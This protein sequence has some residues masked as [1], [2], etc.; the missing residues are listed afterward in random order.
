LL[1]TG[2]EVWQQTGLPRWLVDVVAYGH[3][4]GFLMLTPLMPVLLWLALDRRFVRQLWV[5]T[6][7]A[8]A[9]AH[10]ACTVQKPGAVK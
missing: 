9:M 7:L 5:E 4:F 8:S 2:P 1:T 6:V 3:Q 10:G